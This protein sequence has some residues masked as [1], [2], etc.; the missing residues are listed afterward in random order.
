MEIW[1][2]ISGYEGIY[3]ISNKGNI[4]S[5]SRFHVPKDRILTGFKSNNGYVCIELSKEGFSSRFYVHRIM[6]IAFLPNPYN[7]P[8][9]NHKDGVRNNNNLDNIEW[10]TQK[11]NIQHAHR[12]GLARVGIGEKQAH[13]KLKTNNINKIRS[14]YRTGAYTM[15]EIGDIYK[16]SYQSISDVVN[17][18]T[19]KHIIEEDIKNVRRGV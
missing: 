3:K 4:K 5:L 2:D 1:K 7:K 15:K 6:A 10:C 18:R 8:N 19:W 13:S 11:E 14:M 9:I 17:F 12:T 16:V